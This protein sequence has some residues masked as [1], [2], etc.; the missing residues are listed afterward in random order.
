MLNNK[1]VIYKAN[2]YVD[3]FTIGDFEV[4]ISFISLFEDS[5][6]TIIWGSLFIGLFENYSFDLPHCW[7]KFLCQMMNHMNQFFYFRSFVTFIFGEFEQFLSSAWIILSWLALLNDFE[8]S[9]FVLFDFV[10][11]PPSF[12]V[13]EG[14]PVSL[15]LFFMLSTLI[16]VRKNSNSY[17]LKLIKAEA[18]L[19][20]ILKCRLEVVLLKSSLSHGLLESPFLLD[21]YFLS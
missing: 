13:F 7:C 16:S 10:S 14:L 18:P 21:L 20:S 9:L 4:S 11:E 6:N 19:S 1:L 15:N 3:D 2:K 8:N 5:V 12:G 17:S